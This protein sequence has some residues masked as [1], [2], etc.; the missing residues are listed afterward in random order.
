M[1]MVKIAVI[2]AGSFVFGPSVLSQALLEHRLDD[3]ELALVDLDRDALE[4][5]AGLGRRM[6]RETGVRA[7]ITT[8]QDRTLAL[9]GADFVIC[10]AAR[11]LH[12]RFETDCAIIDRLL[13]GH[14]VT[15]F[16]GIAGLS[17]T[18]RQI[19]LIDEICAD[20]QRLAPHAWLLVSS[21]PMPRVCQAAHAFGIQTAGFCSVSLDSYSMLWNIWHGQPLHYPF[22]AAREQWRV[23]MAG[24]NH[25]CW[26]TE[27]VDRASGAD[28][29]P[30]LRQRYREGASSG[31]PRSDSLFN[32]TGYLLVPNDGHTR[33][34]LPPI[35]ND[36]SRNA[37]A[38][39]SPVDRQQRLT[40]LGEIAAGKAPLELVLDH[41]AWE[42]PLDLIA[43]MAFDTPVDFHSLNL[44]NTGQIPNLPRGIFVETPATVSA[45][46]PHPVSVTLP[47]EVLPLCERT[48]LVSDTI[49]R[50]ALGRDRRLVHQAVAYDLTVLDTAA[51][52]AAIDA[53]LEAHADVLPVYQ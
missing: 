46:E 2:G 11:Q 24:L 9:D 5:M 20:M 39:G 45:G 28:L 8:H 40:M 52:I 25:F 19:A 21:N 51:G 29:I 34:F 1:A 49:V 36:L 53:C 16:G 15:E 23:T 48:A 30:E 31:H 22:A 43:A 44:V 10:S 47:P 4:G 3:I 14:L 32:E 37:P 12:R 6:M 35:G 27:I 41:P 13:P 33:D 50:A 38:H 17:Y 7:S 42:R 18:L 26:V